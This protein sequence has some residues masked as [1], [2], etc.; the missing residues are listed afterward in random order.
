MNPL[1]NDI[2][3]TISGFLLDYIY[4][5]PIKD[6]AVKRNALSDIGIFSFVWFKKQVL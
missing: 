1:N 6:N 2:L 4:R 5:I 3:P